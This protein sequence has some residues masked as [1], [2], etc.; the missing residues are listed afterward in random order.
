[1][2]HAYPVLV[3]SV[4]FLGICLGRGLTRPWTGWQVTRNWLRFALVSVA[5]LLALPPIKQFH[6]DVVRWYFTY[7]IAWGPTGQFRQAVIDTV[8]LFAPTRQSYFFAFTTHPFPG[9][10][11]ASYTI[12]DYSGRSIVQ[13]FIP[14]H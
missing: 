3:C 2:Y 14:A 10:P 8:N 6:D 9:F 5:V 4:T 12:A 11:T 7:N 13:S 1:V